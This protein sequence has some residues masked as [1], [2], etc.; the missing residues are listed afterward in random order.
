MKKVLPSVAFGAALILATVLAGCTG[1]HSTSELSPSGAP[2]SVRRENPAGLIVFQ[3][4]PSGP[5]SSIYTMKPDGTA[6][7]RLTPTP[8][9]D[10]DFHPWLSPDG[11][12][13]LFASARDSRYSDLYTISVK[14][15]RLRRITNDKSASRYAC[16]VS[17][18][19]RNRARR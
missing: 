18:P 2:S 19:D 11:S 4:H 13:I 8:P 17:A 12:Q 6:L 14:D 7:T 9:G 5:Y 16:F 15:S 1:E 3:G 10:N